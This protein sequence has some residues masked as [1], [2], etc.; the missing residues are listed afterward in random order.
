ME[1]VGVWAGLLFRFLAFLHNFRTRTSQSTQP[2]VL[3][4][5]F[6]EILPASPQR[7]KP[8]HLGRAEPIIIG[9]HHFGG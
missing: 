2:K 3:Q 6:P 1:P 4:Q 7:K 5:L 8:L 9:G